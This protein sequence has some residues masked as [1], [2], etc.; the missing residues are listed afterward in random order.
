MSKK[1][2]FILIMLLYIGIGGFL[3]AISRFLL[4]NSLQKSF[5]MVFP[6]GTLGVNVVGSL[7]IGFFAFYFSSITIPEYRGL[8]ITGFL[9]ALTTFST[10]SYETIGL[11][12]HGSYIK[13]VLNIFLNV[14]LSLGATL[15]GMWIFK[16]VFGS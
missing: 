14:S 8:V 6:I 11:F 15:I 12:E 7:L 9:G 1:E 16:K 3:G 4:S 10:F 2:E 13:A 5:D